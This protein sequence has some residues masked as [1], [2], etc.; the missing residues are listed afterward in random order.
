M[1]SGPTSC[2][3]VPSTP[4]SPRSTSNTRVPD[5]PTEIWTARLSARDPDTLNVTR[6]SGDPVF[7]PSWELLRTALDIR[8]SGRTSTDQEW[9]DYAARYL[10]EMAASYDRHRTHW[11]ELLARPRVVLTCY[12]TNADRCH[13]KVLAR[14]LEKLGAT[15]RGELPAEGASEREIF[16]LAME[17]GGDD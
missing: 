14:V 6:K 4:T 2:P 10:R 3:R 1:P 13:R 5:V 7:A 9:K 11:V 16:A 8:H 17:L 15:Y 12:C